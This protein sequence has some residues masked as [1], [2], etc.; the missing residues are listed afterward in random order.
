M[1]LSYENG[2]T[3]YYCDYCGNEVTIKGQ[4]PPSS[5]KTKGGMFTTT[6][7]YCGERCYRD[8]TGK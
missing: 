6:K 2:Y 5:W 1:A 3:T 4:R 7:H 8:A